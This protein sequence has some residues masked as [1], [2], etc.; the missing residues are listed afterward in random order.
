MPP[1]VRR[2]PN[3]ARLRRHTPCTWHRHA[4]LG[5]ADARPRA[6]RDDRPEL[7]RG[8]D[9]CEARD[10]RGEAGEGAHAGNAFA[11]GSSAPRRPLPTTARIAAFT[12]G[13]RAAS[14]SAAHEGVE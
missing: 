2:I 12:A 14:R 9:S 4:L 11:M 8:L 13:L 1:D 6:R 5:P 3:P 10:G 7:S